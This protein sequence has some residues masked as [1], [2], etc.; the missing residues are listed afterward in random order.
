MI[1]LENLMAK[2]GD[3]PSLPIVIQ[4]LHTSISEQDISVSEIAQIIET[5]QAFTAR[6][7]RLVNS[8]F[9]GL[10]GRISSVESAITILGFDAVHQLLLTASVLKN[11]KGFGEVINIMDFWKHSF[12]VGVIAKHLL[13]K[14]DKETQNTASIC[15]ILHDIG[16]LMFIRMDPDKF[17]N[18]YAEMK[19]VTDLDTEREY[20]S[21][22]HQDMGKLLAQ[23]WNFPG[24][25]ASAIANHHT[26]L[27][28]DE[29]SLLV[30]AINIADLL[31][32]A[33]DLGDSSNYYVSEYFP[34][35]WAMLDV[36][37]GD[38]ESILMNSLNEI[39]GLEKMIRM[40]S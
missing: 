39:E 6:L 20:F 23:K 5:D 15:G 28:T 32:H 40:M 33:L 30:S 11:F 35:A 38:L 16:R 14:A 31:C 21:I 34:E 26:P 2:V 1:N 10:T 25:I 18:F 9:Y 36:S 3:L 24:S 7:L 4:R 17:I 22:D 12:C 27:E 37:I 29:N 8:P 19:M 13:H